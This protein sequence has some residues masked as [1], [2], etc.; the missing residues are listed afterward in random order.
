MKADFHVHTNISDGY[1]NI[2][3]IVKMAKKNGLTHIAITNHDTVEGLEEAINLGIL[4]GLKVIPG[5]EISAFNFEK[6]KKVHILGFNFNI[7]GKNIKKLCDPILQ[8]RNVNS[9]LQ[10]NILIN[11]GYNINIK[12]ILHRAKG[13]EVIYKQHIMAELIDNGYTN[14]IYSDLYNKLFKN[15]GICDMNIV[16]VDAVDAVRAIKSDGGIAILAHPGQLDSYDIIDKLVDVGLDGLE[17][18]HEDHSS[19]DIEKIKEY[20]A[21]YGLVLTG[22]SDFHGKYG[23]GIKLGEINCPEKTIYMLD[24]SLNDLG[25][26]GER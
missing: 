4:E 12:N 25:C 2:K 13:S 15:Q 26:L 3:E 16:Y 8:K 24:K 11:N 23:S 5:V 17:L 6:N 19:N 1:N 21:I 20:S 22:G 14:A 9:I 7:N 10:I 18:N